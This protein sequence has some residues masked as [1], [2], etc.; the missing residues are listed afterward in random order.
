AY[1]VQKTCL[2]HFGV[3]TL[4]NE[5]VPGDPI[6]QL[7]SA[8]SFGV[9][10]FFTISGFILIVPFVKHYLCDGA[11]PGLGAYYWRRV[12][13]LEP[14]YMIHLIF[15]VVLSCLVL[16]RM[17][18]HPGLYQ[19]DAWPGFLFKHM[20]PS[21]FYANG[22]VFAKLPYP[23]KV[24]WSLETEIQFYLVAPLLALLFRISNPLWRRSILIGLTVGSS[25]LTSFISQ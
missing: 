15:L 7:F 11:R 3:T 17:P 14:P 21:F 1:H 23:N 19:N 20:F 9:L 12:T 10:L 16:R 6:N 18:S 24:L 5:T 8:G 4:E 2:F 25:F 13:R 22:F